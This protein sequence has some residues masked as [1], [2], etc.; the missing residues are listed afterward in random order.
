MRLEPVPD[1]PALLVNKRTLAVADLHI[2]IEDELRKAGFFLP[3]QTDKIAK[4]LEE[5]R[6]V[7]GAPRLVILGDVKH[8]VSGVSGLENRDLP[9]FFERLSRAFDDIYIAP[10]NHDGKIKV[11][12]PK[13]V[14]FMKTS[15]FVLDRVGYIHGHAWPG[16][17]VMRSQ[18]LIMGHN[19]PAVM[20]IDKL[21]TKTIRPC[22]M[23][24]DFRGRSKKFPK[25]PK[26]AVVVPSFNELCGGV[27]VNDV[28]TIF[29]GP[30]MR[31]TYV[32]LRNARL[33]LL[34]GTFLG[35]MGNLTVDSGFTGR[36]FRQ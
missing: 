7:T 10:G 8:N 9:S 4:R 27:P 29:M 32:D 11:L 34:D 2:G 18:H 17:E 24:V 1:H 23:R 14:R 3:S 25:M 16:L 22:W 26:D 20:L 33:Y 35:S 12:L 28:S 30:L 36:D 21:G 6:R 31:D 19:H 5:L 13:S 15:G